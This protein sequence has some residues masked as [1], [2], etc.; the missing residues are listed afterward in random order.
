MYC[1]V[2]S[3][4][5]TLCSKYVESV[6]VTFSLIQN[7]FLSTGLIET[8]DAC[9]GLPPASTTRY[10]LPGLKA[11]I[12]LSAPWSFSIGRYL[13]KSDAASDSSDIIR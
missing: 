7:L 3:G 5:A 9:F 11:L 8:R 13:Q 1:D 6:I 2:N 12:P 4:C 10:R